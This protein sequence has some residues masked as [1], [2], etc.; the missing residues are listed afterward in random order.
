ME[1]DALRTLIL[2]KLRDGRL[3]TDH[4]LRFWAGPS[5]AEQCMACDRLIAEPLV[6]EGTSSSV[7]GSQPM[8]MHVGC[9]AIWD[10]ERNK[11]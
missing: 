5:E 1:A 4:I 3:P 9:F 11:L 8:Q 7:G 2:Q 6:V 10:E